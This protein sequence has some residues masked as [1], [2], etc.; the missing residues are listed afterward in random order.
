MANDEGIPEIFEY[1]EKGYTQDLLVALAGRPG[2]LAET[3]LY[4]IGNHG[5]EKAVEFLE[6]VKRHMPV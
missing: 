3:T 4:I 1:F 5:T 6:F 2:L